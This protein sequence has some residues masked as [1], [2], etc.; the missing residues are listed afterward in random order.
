MDTDRSDRE[1]AWEL[2]EIIPTAFIFCVTE[3]RRWSL[4]AKG[5]GQRRRKPPAVTLPLWASIV[6]PKNEG[7]NSKFSKMRLGCSVALASLIIH[8]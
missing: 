8:F 7:T 2:E 5:A 3:S 1:R 4:N 6:Y